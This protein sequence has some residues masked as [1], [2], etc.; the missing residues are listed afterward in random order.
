M[1]MP[2]TSTRA[3]WSRLRTPRR[4]VENKAYLA[5]MPWSAVEDL[6]SFICQKGGYQFGRTSDGYNPACELW[7]GSYATEMTVMET[8]ELCRK[9]HR[10]APFLFMNGNTFANLAKIALEPAF[11]SLPADQVAVYRTAVG[12][13]V[14]GTIGAHEL[15][16]ALAVQLNK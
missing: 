8:A 2:P 5:G 13:Y 16:A 15:P 11:T 4:S 7:N 10:L 3:Q 9:C 14:A 12:H 6:N 1:G